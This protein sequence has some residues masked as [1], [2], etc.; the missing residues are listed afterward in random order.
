MRDVDW[1]EITSMFVVISTH[2]TLG[3]PGI[4]PLSLKQRKLLL[5]LLLNEYVNYHEQPT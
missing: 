5:F 1:F 2:F 3:L 4:S